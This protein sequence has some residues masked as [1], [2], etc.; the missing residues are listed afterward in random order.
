[1]ERIF[2]V[3]IY[4]LGYI[5]LSVTLVDALGMWDVMSDLSMALFM[6]VGYL[7]SVVGFVFNRRSSN[8]AETFVGMAVDDWMGFLM[9]FTG[10]ALILLTFLYAL[11][12]TNRLDSWGIWG[13]PFFV[14][15]GV[16]LCVTGFVFAGA[17]VNNVVGRV[18]RKY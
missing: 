6:V 14:V 7:L 3:V 9:F 1:M 15:I 13:V 12:L 16:I 5:M 2:G 8:L 4:M 17:T 11:G 18:R 10:I